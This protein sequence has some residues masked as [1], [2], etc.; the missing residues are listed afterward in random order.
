MRTPNTVL[1]MAAVDVGA[2]GA[3][4]LAS[5]EVDD[6]FDY[7]V[8]DDLLKDAADGAGKVGGANAKPTDGN[9]GLD[10][11]VKIAKKRAPIPKLDE[12]R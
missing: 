10:E 8:P 3:P 1:A 6:L 4:P 12:N 5:V 9:L 7:G 2:R 11:E